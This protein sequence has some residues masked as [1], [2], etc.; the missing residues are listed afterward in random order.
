MGA[1]G[2]RRLA[3]NDNI[4]GAD[5]AVW[6]QTAASTTPGT[7]T[8]PTAVLWDME[9]TLVDTEPYWMET[10]F[11]LAAEYGATWTHE[12]ALQ[13]VGNDL[14]TSGRFIQENMGLPLSP[15]EIVERLL[16][17]VVERVRYD[18]PWR[19]GAVDLLEQLS[20]AGVPCALVTMSWERFVAPILAALPP[21]TFTAVVT[22][23]NVTHG[24]PHPEPYLT[25]AARLG[26]DATTTIAIED[27]EPGC[28]SAEAAGCTVL[29]VPL[30]VSV[31]AG[32]RRVF[33]DSLLGLDPAAL[34]AL[35]LP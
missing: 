21:D 29:A 2:S 8:L 17:G 1:A 18:V 25:A 27:S 20:A 16:D 22:G 31:A 6:D 7:P 15:E 33:R 4:P 24:K 14:L 19:P 23:D 35:R 30:H 28:R 9:G 13:L 10:E 11:A 3:T 32:E 5:V 12:L 26:V 34:G